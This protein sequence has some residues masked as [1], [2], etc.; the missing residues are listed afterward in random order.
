METLLGTTTFVLH[1]VAVAG[2]RAIA[3]RLAV[4]PGLTLWEYAALAELDERG[5]VAQNV[6]AEALGLD[7]SDV[8][9]LMDELL[10]AQLVTRDRDAED[11][12]R[13]RIALTAK[14]RR[15]LAT[16]HDVVRKVEEATLAPL[17]PA[18]RSTLHRLVSKVHTNSVAK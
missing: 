3:E 12:R 8:V 1:R 13:Y 9:K 18:E 15:S 4:R 11:R 16:G 7:P 5:P 6:V 14:G 10:T 17:S 2:R